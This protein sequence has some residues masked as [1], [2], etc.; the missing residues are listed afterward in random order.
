MT[1]VTPLPPQAFDD[2]YAPREAPQ[3][4]AREPQPIASPR[5]ALILPDSAPAVRSEQL[6]KIARQADRQTMHGY[7]LASHGALFAAREE[8]TSALRLVAQGLDAEHQTT[9]HSQALGCGLTALKEVQDFL[10]TGNKLEADLDMPTIVG[11]HRTPVLKS[12]PADEL[13]PMTAVKRYFTFAQEQLAA[14]AGHEVAGSMALCGLGKL[15]VAFGNQKMLGVV[16]AE[17]KAMVFFQASLLVYPQNHLASNEL[18]V[19][20]AHCGNYADARRALEHSVSICR[21]SAGFDN[22]AVV[23]QQQGDRQSA[24]L[25]SRFAAATRRN[26]EARLRGVYGSASGVVQWVSPPALAQAR[27]PASSASPPVQT[28]TPPSAAKPVAAGDKAGPSTSPGATAPQP[29]IGWAPWSSGAPA[30]R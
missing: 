10:P 27:S 4:D 21:T 9:V 30:S 19:L 8:C 25:A 17:P 6:E 5:A 29:A 3:A 24:E 28:V 23:Y 2:R 26:E 20:L 11:S 18:G 14:A 1:A 22:L 13:R 15:H 7:E 12:C 16:A